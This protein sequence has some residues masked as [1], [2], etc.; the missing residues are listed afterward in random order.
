MFRTVC[1]V[2]GAAIG[3]A[4]PGWAAWVPA[5]ALSPEVVRYADAVGALARHVRHPVPQAGTQLWLGS[6]KIGSRIYAAPFNAQAI[7]VYDVATHTSEFWGDFNTTS[8]WSDFVYVPS[9]GLLYGIP[10]SHPLILFFNPTTN[11]SEVRV[12]SGSFSAKWTSGVYVAS[13]GRVYG[14]PT[15][16]DYILDFDPATNTTQRRLSDVQNNNNKW[17]YAAYSA[18]YNS[19]IFVPGDFHSFAYVNL[20]TNRNVYVSVDP[21]EIPGADNKWSKG[22]VIG[23]TYYALPLEGGTVLTIDLA[24][25]AFG[26]ESR[27]GRGA[28]WGTTVCVGNTLYGIPSGPP[29]LIEYNVATRSHTLTPLG[30]GDEVWGEAHYDAASGSI[31][32]VSHSS[33]GVLEVFPAPR[34]DS[35]ALLPLTSGGSFTWTVANAS[36]DPVLSQRL[37]SL[38]D[39]VRALEA[40]AGLTAAPTA[41]ATP[42]PATAAPTTTPPTTT[43]PTTAAPARPPTATSS[44]TAAPAQPPPASSGQ[45]FLPAC[46][47]GTVA[48]NGQCVPACAELRRRGASCEPYCDRATPS[49]SAADN[50]GLYAGLVAAFA[51]AAVAGVAY[52]AHV[53]RGKSLVRHAD[54]VLTNPAYDPRGVSAPASGQGP[55]VPPRNSVRGHMYEP[56][57]GY[58]PA[59]APSASSGYIKV[60]ADADASGDAVYQAISETY[61]A[62]TLPSRSATPPAYEVATA[63]RRIAFPGRFEESAVYN[64]S[65]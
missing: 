36:G 51:A 56:P 40:S 20:T 39:R 18:A 46:G 26:R 55:P 12:N 49:E 59:Y 53:R 2:L 31:F 50:T 5:S 34:V 28:K 61:D 17:M 37:D 35:R 14:I 43:P 25:T 27:F 9:T 19:L 44:A 8:Q 48:Q 41:R 24:T 16:V 63:G 64:L 1:L 52:A 45:C 3:G 10:Y 4:A 29:T 57:L 62:A 21:I 7:L 13:T 32:A 58:N 65:T 30:G 6:E 11:V 33:G 15:S 42:P 47:A 54:M 60:D 38:D 22:C 23:N